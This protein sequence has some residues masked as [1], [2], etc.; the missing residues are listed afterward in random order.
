MITDNSV[1]MR[2]AYDKLSNKWPI[3]ILTFFIYLTIIAS[4]GSIKHVGSLLSLFITGPFLL[5]G[6]GFSLAIY[7]DKEFKL[8][9]IFQGFNRFSTSVSA[10]LTMI[11]LIILWSILFIIPGIIAALSYSLTFYILS[12]DP[13]ISATAALNKSKKM[14]DGYKLKLFNLYLRL[15]LLTLL[16]ILTLGIGFFWFIPYK[17]ITMAAFY[18]ELNSQTDTYQYGV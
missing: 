16:C 6:A 7:R 5:G 18:E 12:D 15:F 1:L 8:E 3:A 13:S 11:L 14:M 2:K 4:V 17:N 10:Y 9:M